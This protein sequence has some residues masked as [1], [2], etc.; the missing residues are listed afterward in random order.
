MLSVFVDTSALYALLDADD[1]NHA[2][3]AAYFPE[4]RA[5]EPTTHNYVALETSALVAARLGRRALRALHEVALPRLEPVWVDAAVHE[6]A[7]AML[8]SASSRRLS[9]VDCASFEVMRRFGIETAFAFDRDFERQGF[10]TV[11]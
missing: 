10:R 3:A 9:L 7:V 2:A 6:A 4:L 1:S 8:L 5:R 11:P